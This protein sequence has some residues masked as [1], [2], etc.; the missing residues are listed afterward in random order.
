MLLLK[1][2]LIIVGSGFFAAAAAVVLIE[3]Y[4]ARRAS[5][6][7]SVEWRRAVQS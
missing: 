2:G 4:A 5:R 7:L 1:Y 3:V 6:P